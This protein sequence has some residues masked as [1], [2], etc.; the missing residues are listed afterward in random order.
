MALL[1]KFLFQ[2]NLK[3]V[4]KK[5]HCVKSAEYILNK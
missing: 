4:Y 3:K 2:I 5:T 1:D